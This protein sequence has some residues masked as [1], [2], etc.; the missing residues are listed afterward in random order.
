MLN[1]LLIITII[2]TMVGVIGTGFGGLL[3]LLWKN[4]GSKFMSIILGFSGGLMLSVVTFDLLPEAFEIGGIPLSIL[5]IIFGI[6]VTTL[7][8]EMLPD[9]DNMAKGRGKY[10]KMGILLALG[11]ALHN[12]PEGLA[13]G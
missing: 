7:I 10:F 3:S 1:N 12:F 2:G 9:F 13:I 4:P 6:I 5:G 8:D 11:L